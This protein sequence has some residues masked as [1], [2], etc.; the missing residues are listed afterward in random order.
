MLTLRPYQQIAFKKIQQAFR[1]GIKHTILCMPTGAGKT[2]LF[3]YLAKQ[4]VNKGKKVLVLTD[5]SELL[6]QAGGACKK[7]EL[8][9]FYIQ[10][11]CQVANDNFSVYVAMSQT[12]RRRIKK[13]Y[14]KQFLV[15]IDLV[16]IDECHKQ[17]FNYV[18]E[19]GLVNDKYVIG[20]TATPK[21]GGSMR[22]LALDYETIIE[23]VTVK[24][25]INQGYLVN[26]D[27]Y[28]MDS[29]SMSN[30][31]FNPLTGDYQE[32]SMFER[33]NTTKLYTGVINNYK[34]LVDNT[35]SLVFCVNIEH[36]I[37]TTLKFRNAGYDARFL[38]SEL[39]KPT[40]KTNPNEGDKVRYQERL[41]IYNLYRQN[42][43]IC[44]GNRRDI[45]RDYV[46]NK[47]THLVN[48]SILTT[49]FDC[50]DIETII[51]NRATVSTTLLLQMLGRGSRIHDNKSH[52]NILDFGGNCS[53]LGNYSENRMWSLW[54]E[55]IQGEGLPPV[56]DC[57]TDS[58]GKPI[59]SNKK[60]CGR[61]I[62]ASYK[63]C[64]FCGFKYPDK[65]M[66]EIELGI[67]LPETI[68]GPK[69]RSFR[70]MTYKQLY[71]YYNYKKHK[72]PWLWRQLWYRGKNDELIKFA[73]LYNWDKKTLNTAILYCKNH[74]E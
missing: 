27:Y 40:L 59:I 69:N 72:A 2:I 25:L 10:A 51:L 11:G 14:W 12:F 44:S 7:I 61:M 34:K 36:A 3:T 33:F 45:I 53:R 54:H 71:E 74:I 63:I 38:V 57:G 23:T 35:K 52:F 16:I 49:G 13:S 58:T 30:V 24:Q 67:Q 41:K 20:F 64:P 9:P 15:G 28:G 6:L 8:Q 62:L 18:F 66:K 32:K 31:A 60:G 29:P 68:V 55:K 65:K 17:E 37:K 43:H 56:K 26:D 5:R 1:E 19:S 73:S 47:F 48:A 42:F 46:H 21:R 70:H 39:S 50:P 4:V 22:Q